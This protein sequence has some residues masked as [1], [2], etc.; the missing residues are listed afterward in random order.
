VDFFIPG[1][2][3]VGGF[4]FVSAPIMSLNANASAVNALHLAPLDS[5]DLAVKQSRHPPAAWIHSKQC[6]VGAHVQV[7][8]GGK[9]TLGNCNII[10]PSGEFSDRYSTLT[11]IAGGVGINPLFSMLLA[12]ADKAAANMMQ[13]VTETAGAR[14]KRAGD[15][16]S[17]FLAYSCRNSS[18]F[19]FLPALRWL[20]GN[21][22]SPLHGKLSLYLTA[23]REVADAKGSSS[24]ASNQQKHMHWPCLDAGIMCGRLNLA[25]LDSVLLSS[26]VSSNSSIVKQQLTPTTEATSC[27]LLCGPLQMSNELAAHYSQV[28]HANFVFFPINLHYS[29]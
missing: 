9:F 7:R 23:S 19:L 8:V 26:P 17:I 24:V 27:V 15:I 25:V 18:D 11:L 1:V 6:A 5:F 3:V 29:Y 2:E 28:Y 13:R 21:T 20:A 4:S 12:L 10:A 16:P 14:S 22:E